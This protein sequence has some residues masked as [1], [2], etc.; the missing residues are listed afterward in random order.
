[1]SAPAGFASAPLDWAMTQNNLGTALQILGGRESGMA[2][3]EEAVQAYRAAPDEFTKDRVPL[4]WE[5]TQNNLDSALQ[6]LGE[7]QSGHDGMGGP[8]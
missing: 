2:R 6:R 5:A 7:R 4:D 8:D 1:V 3:L